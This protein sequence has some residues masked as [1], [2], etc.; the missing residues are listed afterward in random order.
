MLG[1]QESLVPGAPQRAI[2]GLLLTEGEGEGRAVY[3]GRAAAMRP[4]HTPPRRRRRLANP[5]SS[6]NARALIEKPLP[7]AR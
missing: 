2:R 5:S 6:K 7:F 3:L 1:A 4:G